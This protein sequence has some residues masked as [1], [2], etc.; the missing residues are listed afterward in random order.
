MNG[1][2]FNVDKDDNQ[3]P[4]SFANIKVEDLPDTVDWRDKVSKLYYYQLFGL[5][6]HLA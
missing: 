2:Q 3:S 6:R 1:V 5:T 4:A